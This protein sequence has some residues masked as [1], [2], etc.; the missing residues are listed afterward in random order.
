MVKNTA[1]GNKAKGFAR[2]G[3]NNDK[4]RPLRV[5]E[6]E[7]E[8][9]AIV[10]K[11]YGNSMCDVMCMDGEI[12]MLHIRGK[13]KGRGKRDNVVDKTSWLLVGIRD[14]ETVKD[15]K[16]QNCDLLEVY[17]D[18]EKNKL[19]TTV[20]N[21]N[22]KRF[23][24]NDEFTNQDD[25]DNNNEDDNEFGFEFADQ[26]TQEYMDLMDKLKKSKEEVEVVSTKDEDWI[27]MDEI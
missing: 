7:N 18:N 26:Q 21:V 23:I 13:F 5:S 3:T 9:Y 11:Y 8:I 10:D 27:N 2:K 15:S 1:G 16:K 20:K 22:W 12:R 6:N 19:K 24:K 25:N 17:N 14:Y 4:D